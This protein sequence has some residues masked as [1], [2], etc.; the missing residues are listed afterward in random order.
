MAIPPGACA[1]WTPQPGVFGNLDRVTLVFDDAAPDFTI[2][3]DADTG[4]T[5]TIGTT[6]GST[7]IT[8]AAMV[9]LFNADPAASALLLME[10]N[11]NNALPIDPGGPIRGGSAGEGAGQFFFAADAAPPPPAPPVMTLTFKGQ[12]VYA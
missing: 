7:N 8:W 3:V 12:K 5:L 9:V 10:G 1:G 4:V 6:A 11:A 2:L